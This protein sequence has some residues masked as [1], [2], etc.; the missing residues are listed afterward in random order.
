MGFPYIFWNPA[1]LSGIRLCAPGGGNGREAHD[2]ESS[3]VM[4]ETS[5]SQSRPLGEGDLLGEMVV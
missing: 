2:S 1:L 5:E 3:E 4:R